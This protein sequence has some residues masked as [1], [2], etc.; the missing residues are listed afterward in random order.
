[1]EII[2]SPNI[3]LSEI[4]FKECTQESLEI[5]DR[6]AWHTHFSTQASG[7]KCSRVIISKAKEASPEE[8]DQKT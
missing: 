4:G 1:M 2:G 7:T 5:R 6:G 8:T 3:L